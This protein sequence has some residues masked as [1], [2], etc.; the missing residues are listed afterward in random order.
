MNEPHISV[1]IPMY[2]LEKHIDETLCSVL[3]S[4]LSDCEIICVN[5]GSTDQTSVICDKYIKENPKIKLVNTE[6]RGVSA[7]RNIGLE[8]AAGKYVLFMDGDDMLT[9]N[10]LEAVA[11][12]TKEDCDILVFGAEI[13]GDTT[14]IPPDFITGSRCDPGEFEYS[15]EILFDRDGVFPFIW[16]KAF[17][18]RFLLDNFLRFDVNL[19]LGEDQVF[20]LSAFP[21]AKK[22]RFISDKLYVYRFQRADSASTIMGKNDCV[23]C[24]CHLDDLEKAAA[25]WQRKNYFKGAETGF[26]KWCVYFA[27]NTVLIVKSREKSA[28]FAKRLMEI[29]VKYDIPYKMAEPKSYLKFCIVKYPLLLRIFFI[30]RIFKW[31]V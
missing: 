25:L 9:K 15:A 22:I 14:N 8:K 7:A 6:N 30:Y 19:R 17:R 31:H 4:D 20:L 23:R 2:N 5:D 26:C 13:I 27:V 24:A 29:I 10:A 16:N 3:S 18:R 1:V 21:A 12:N 28:A 11:V